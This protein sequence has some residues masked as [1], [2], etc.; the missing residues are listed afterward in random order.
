ML[1]QF[2]QV[3]EY[4]LING[5]VA[6]AQEVNM[7]SIASTFIFGIDVHAS[8]HNGG[9]CLAPVKNIVNKLNHVFGINGKKHKW[10]EIFGDDILTNRNL[11]EQTFNEI[12]ELA[13][14][15]IPSNYT[16]GGDILLRYRGRDIIVR[17]AYNSSENI[18]LFGDAWV[19]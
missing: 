3:I 9:V 6:Y 1:R 2:R 11:Q 7:Q 19:K 18:F 14:K 16:T 8:S 13:A 15:N 5:R 17:G 10:H 12:S 4:C